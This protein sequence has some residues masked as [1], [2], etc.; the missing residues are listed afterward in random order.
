MEVLTFKKSL[1]LLQLI[2]QKTSTVLAK[3]KK[4]PNKQTTA[5]K[6]LAKPVANKIIKSWLLFGLIALI[7]YGITILPF[8]TEYIQ[9]PIAR[10]FTYLS[11]GV[12]NI[13]GQETT[14]N[15]T[16][17]STDDGLVLSVMKGCDAIAPI[18]L[19]VTG[20]LMFPVDRKLKIRGIGVGVVLLF[21]VNLLRIVSLFFFL[22]Y[23]PSIFEFM[24]N[25]FWQV[26]FIGITILYYI[27][28]LNTSLKTSPNVTTA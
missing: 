9:S 15:L 18:I 7:F 6:P 19:L 10:V 23:T 1:Y 21:L 24:H 3:K 12:L 16:T 13:F 11:S 17:L 28:W 4:K 27:Y 8:Y 22:K 26:A 2:S 5:K 20:V 14:S 25:E